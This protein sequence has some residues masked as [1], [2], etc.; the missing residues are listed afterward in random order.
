MRVIV[1]QFENFWAAADPPVNSPDISA[2][3]ERC[4]LASI[5]EK[6]LTRV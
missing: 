4:G 5:P 3:R 6:F 2:R 1:R